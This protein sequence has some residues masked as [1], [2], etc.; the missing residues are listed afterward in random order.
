MSYLRQVRDKKPSLTQPG[1]QRLKCGFRA[2]TNGRA[3]ELLARTGSLSGHPSKQQ[4]RST[5]TNSAILR[6]LSYQLLGFVKHDCALKS[7]IFAL[8]VEQLY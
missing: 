8:F 2:S 5:L 4:P 1:D 6:Q 7:T 3:G